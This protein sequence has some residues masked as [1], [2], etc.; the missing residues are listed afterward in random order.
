VQHT[1][2]PRSQP[3]LRHPPPTRLVPAPAA[4]DDAELEARLAKLRKAKG[5]TPYGE[6]AK[7][8]PRPD[9][10][11]AAA[12][13]SSSEP[14]P[15]KEYDFSNETLFWE[16]PPARG[17]L[18]FNLALSSTLILIPVA[19]GAVGRALFVN[20][21]FTDKRFSVATTAPWKSEHG[22]CL[23]H[24]AAGQAPWA[25]APLPCSRGR[26]APPPRPRRS[27]PTQRRPP[28]PSPTRPCPP[29]R[30]AEEQTDVAYQEIKDVVTV[31]RLFGA[32]GDMVSGAAAVPPRRAGP[33][34]ADGPGS[35]PCAPAQTCLNDVSSPQ[36]LHSR[37]QQPRHLVARAR[38]RCT[39]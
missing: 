14:A 35:S 37:A 22:S 27:T 11:A 16:G 13:A 15:K 29:C 20:Y 39:C 18:A 2:P 36:P 26:A 31:T 38:A 17:D 9:K 1:Q 5:A 32:W 6:G 28:P 10:P 3:P 7:Q 12:A 8:T 21:R 34:G 24:A 30:N 23:P 33:G 19:I 25:G 4:D